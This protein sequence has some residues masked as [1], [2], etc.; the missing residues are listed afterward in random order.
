MVQTKGIKKASKNT[1]HCTIVTT[2]SE[3]GTAVVKERLSVIVDGDVSTG[4]GDP[5]IVS[6]LYTLAMKSAKNTGMKALDLKRLVSRVLEQQI[7]SIP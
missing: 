7:R 5:K 6:S 1:I 2:V 4:N 3:S